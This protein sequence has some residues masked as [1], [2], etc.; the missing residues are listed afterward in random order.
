MWRQTPCFANYRDAR[1]R[2]GADGAMRRRK[3]LILRW[4]AGVIEKRSG[5]RRRTGRRS[6]PYTG[7]SIQSVALDQRTVKNSPLDFDTIHSYT[8][9]WRML[10][11]VL[12][13]AGCCWIGQPHCARGEYFGREGWWR[14]NGAFLGVGAVIKPRS[15]I[16]ARFSAF[17]GLWLAGKR[18]VIVQKSVR[19]AEWFASD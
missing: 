4:S 9:C 11:P 3:L 6:L 15:L 13:Q 5:L 19:I 16:T 18:Q 2:T 12:S 10:R 8:I 14:R 7:F 1:G 17:K